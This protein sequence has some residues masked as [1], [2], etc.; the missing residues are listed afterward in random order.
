MERGEGDF[1][2]HR[3]KALQMQMYE[4]PKGASPTTH[5]HI[6]GG[7][8]RNAM[9][10]ETTCVA[11]GRVRRI[12]KCLL[13]QLDLGFPGVEVDVSEE[14]PPRGMNPRFGDDTTRFERRPFVV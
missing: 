6:R 11:S 12:R 1:M 13:P 9:K 4:V 2:I 5:I 7:D 14:V 3:A 10:G 8:V